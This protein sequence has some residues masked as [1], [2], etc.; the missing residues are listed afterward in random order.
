LCCCAVVWQA[1]ALQQA[2]S[3]D[4]ICYTDGYLE[5]HV[6]KQMMKLYDHVMAYTLSLNPR[7]FS[8]TPKACDAA[9]AALHE[10]ASPTE[11]I[12]LKSPAT[13]QRTVRKVPPKEPC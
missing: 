2:R 11:K 10:F 8:F 13:S 1:K 5:Q 6:A 7:A 4:Y 12:L 3:D 9:R